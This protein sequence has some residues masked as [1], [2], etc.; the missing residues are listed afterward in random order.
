[1][2]VQV[3]KE[4]QARAERAKAPQSTRSR[5]G[6]QIIRVSCVELELGREED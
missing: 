3:K 1:V 5:S 4:G 6:P 2:H